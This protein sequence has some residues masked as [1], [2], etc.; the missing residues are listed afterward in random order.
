MSST[1]PGRTIRSG[2]TQNL[3]GTIRPAADKS[4]SH[5][6][7]IFGALAEGETHVKGM[8]E[9]EDVLRTITAFRTMGISIE[10]CN[11]GEYRIQGQG[12]DGLKEPDDV[13]D[14]GNS[15]TAMRLLCGLLA[16]QP[17]HSILTG[18]HSLRSRPM[19]RVV[20]PLTKMGARIRGRDGGR[21]APL[22]IEGTELVPITYNS[23]IASAQVKS[24]I[25]LAG[26]NTAGETTIIEPAVSRDHTERMLIAFGAEVTRDGNQVTIEG[27]PNLQ[28][29]E[30]EVPADISAAAFPMVAALITPGSDII[31]ENVGM[32]PTRTGILDLLLAMG[33]NIQRLNERE[34]G[35]EPVADLQ[36]RYSQLQGIEIDPTVVP[37]AIDE[38]PVFFVAAALA[39]GQT[40]VQGAEELR[41]KES[42]R[43]TAMANGLKALGAIIEERPDGALITGN[44]DGLAG[45][46][47][48]DSFTDH[49]I[50]MSLLVAGLRCK[51]SVLVQRC[52]NINTSF[53][54]FSQLMNSLGFQLED[55]SHG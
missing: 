4:I 6:S 47:S 42:D 19:G 37:R 54:S 39:Q 14:M 25:I 1:H 35:G 49:R 12:L 20:Q 8:L 3:S 27:W 29:Q 21:L 41:V 46:A 51:E 50:A 2:A 31:L 5:R 16:S 15:G 26:L 48:V 55:V 43:I 30:I 52:D 44:P 38:F 40:L 18:D 53:P 10:R 7:V 13:L 28:G 23:P 11:E 24:A 34:V 45:G 32:N 36:V 22:A 33:G 17:F 9:G